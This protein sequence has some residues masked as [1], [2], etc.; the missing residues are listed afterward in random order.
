MAMRDLLRRIGRRRFAPATAAAMLLLNVTRPEH[1]K[2]A[3]KLVVDWGYRLQR[4]AH[5]L[6]ALPAAAQ[7]RRPPASTGQPAI[8]Q[9]VVHFVNRKMTCGLPR[10]NARVV[11]V[12]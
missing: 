4:L 3:R 6:L 7:R 8:R 1:V 11:W 9:Q 10:R 5:R 12:L 2:L